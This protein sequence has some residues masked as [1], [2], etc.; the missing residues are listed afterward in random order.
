MQT[1]LN[2]ENL[3]HCSFLIGNAFFSV[4]STPNK[5]CVTSK[6]GYTVQN[7]LGNLNF[8][9]AKISTILLVPK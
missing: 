4:M 8:Q 1:I 9:D 3:V 2:F 5:Y 6:I 7:A